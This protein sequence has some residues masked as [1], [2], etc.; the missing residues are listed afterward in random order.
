[1]AMAAEEVKVLGAYGSPFSRRVEL[2][3][4]LKGV[5]YEYLEQDLAHKSGL[6]LEHNP[7][8]K[9]VPV[10]VHDGKPVVE[11]L[12]ILEYVEDTWKG[13]HPLLPGDP[14]GRAQ[15]RFWAKFIDDK[16]N[17]AV[18]MS[19]WSRGDTQ[20]MFMEQSKENLKLLEAEL[21]GEEVLRRRRHRA[22][23]RRR[24]LPGTMGRNPSRSERGERD[25]RRE[26]PGVMEVVSGLPELRHCEGLPAGQ[27]SDARLLSIQERGHPTHKS[28][29]LLTHNHK[30]D[31]I[32]TSKDLILP[33][34]SP[35]DTFL[36]T[37][38]RGG[39]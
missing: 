11:S 3:L 25:R 5:P 7:V 24:K 15:A 29:C 32:C 22:R 35:R 23:R 18:W 31:T 27:G 21:K 4:R 20:K 33:C 16:C 36:L 10:L 34:S 14:H 30:S 19:C 38:R 17:S 6:L 39:G 8:Q 12:V 37:E 2:A 26:A 13:G 9:K 1:M 28:S